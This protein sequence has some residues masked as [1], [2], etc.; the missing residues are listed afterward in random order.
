MSSL[1]FWSNDIRFLQLSSRARKRLI[2][3]RCAYVYVCLS[4][5][6]SVCVSACLSVCLP[7]CRSVCLSAC[8]SVC[9]P[10]GLSVCLPARRSVCVLL[11]LLAVDKAFKSKN[12][13][14]LMSVCTY[15]LIT[16][17]GK[18]MQQLKLFECITLCFAPFSVC[19]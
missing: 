12:C 14:F 8:R 10:V 17:S 7:V 4:A 6:L 2:A 11:R 3:N 9:L 19:T 16:R 1:D 15:V 13:F 18:N 5:S